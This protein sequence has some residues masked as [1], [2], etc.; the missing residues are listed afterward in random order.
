MPDVTVTDPTV[1]ARVDQLAAAIAELTT[2]PPRPPRDWPPGMP[3]DPVYADMRARLTPSTQQ[4]RDAAAALLDQGARPGE[5]SPDD[6]FTA[7]LVVGAGDGGWTMDAEVIPL[8]G[9]YAD[10]DDVYA[11]LEA[12]AAEHRGKHPGRLLTGGWCRHYAVSSPYDPHRTG[13]GTPWLTGW[14]QFDAHPLAAD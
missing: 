5:T 9:V 3:V 2:P 8:P 14:A 11:A 13:D 4:D 7:H 6:V 1:T 10:R 12:A